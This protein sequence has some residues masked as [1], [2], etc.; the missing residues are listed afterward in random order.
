MYVYPWDN[1]SAENGRERL[2]GEYLCVFVCTLSI[3]LM[4]ADRAHA[5]L[6]MPSEGT[7]DC[8]SDPLSSAFPLIEADKS[9]RSFPTTLCTSAGLWGDFKPCSLLQALKT[10]RNKKNEVL[11]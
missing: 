3:R 7:M 6:Q 8:I 2:G 9:T 11:D 5:K 1:Q 4:R 10:F